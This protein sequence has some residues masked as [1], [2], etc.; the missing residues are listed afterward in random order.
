MVEFDKRSKLF[1]VVDHFINSNNLSFWFCD[2]IHRRKLLLITLRTLTGYAAIL[3]IL[4]SHWPFRHGISVADGLSTGVPSSGHRCLI[5][6]LMNWITRFR[7]FLW[8]YYTLMTRLCLH[9]MLGPFP[10]NLL[11]TKVSAAC[12]SGSMQTICWQ[13]MPRRKPFRSVLA[14]TIFT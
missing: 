11:W 2:D 8:D 3:F 13:T 7:T 9:Q 10:C 4:K 1:L 12:R 6:S 14:S 5:Y